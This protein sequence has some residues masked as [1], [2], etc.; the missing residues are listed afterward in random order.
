[1]GCVGSR[2]PVTRDSPDELRRS[3]AGLRTL[4]SPEGAMEGSPRARYL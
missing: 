4:I 1:M 2:Q 3:G